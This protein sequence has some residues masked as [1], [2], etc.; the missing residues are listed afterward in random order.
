MVLQ[1]T[2]RSQKGYTGPKGKTVYAHMGVFRQGDSIHL[3]IPQE[4]YF[5]TTVNNK[6]GS[7]RRHENMYKKLKRLLQENDRW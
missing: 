6:A 1:K 2:S 5:H 4:D 7:K 3:T